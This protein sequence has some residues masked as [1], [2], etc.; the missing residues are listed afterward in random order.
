MG[1]LCGYKHR[2][3]GKNHSQSSHNGNSEKLSLDEIAEIPNAKMALGGF[4]GKDVVTILGFV[5]TYQTYLR[6]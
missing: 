1:R 3:I 5:T 6:E 4:A 2:K